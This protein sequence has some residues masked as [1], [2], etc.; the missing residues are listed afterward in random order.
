MMACISD[1]KAN[2]LFYHLGFGCSWSPVHAAIRAI[3]EAVQ[4]RV[5]DIQGARE[6]IKRSDEPP[7]RAFEHGRRAAGLPTGGR[8]YFDGPAGTVALSSLRDKSGPDLGTDIA[9]L[10]GLL[11]EWG[12]T[13]VACVD[14]T[15]PGVPIRVVRVVAPHLERTLVDGTISAALRAFIENPFAVAR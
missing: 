9:R 13:C 11:R 12:E 2:E 3:T 6:D 10:V 15:P 1:T 4:V 8:W 7:V 5:T 14:L